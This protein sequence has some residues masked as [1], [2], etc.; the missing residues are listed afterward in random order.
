MAKGVSAAEKKERMLKLFRESKDVFTK[1]EIESRSTK[2]GIISNAVEGVLKELVGDDLV[3]EEKVGI[4]TYWW[5][6]PGEDAAK[7][8][9]ELSEQ[10]AAVAE[11]TPKLEQLQQQK[12]AAAAAAGGEGDASELQALEASID[13]LR[14]RQKAASEEL[15]KLTKHGSCAASTRRATECRS[16]AARAGYAHRSPAPC[17]HPCGAGQ[18]APRKGTAA[19]AP[20]AY[21]PRAC[22]THRV[23]QAPRTVDPRYLVITPGAEDWGARKADLTVLLEGA[24][25]WTD[26]LCTPMCR[27]VAQRPRPMRPPA[28]PASA[29]ASAGRPPASPSLGQP[30]PTSPSLGQPQPTSPSLAQPRPA[31]ANWQT[32]SGWPAISHTGSR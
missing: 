30:R 8:R 13:A 18:L 17:T 4:S 24:N 1:K 3:R 21:R 31:S 11:L 15:T 27:P 28:R 29:R 12:A 25:R 7:K 16:R 20:Y 10:Q 23:P 26:N 5:S 14:G 32:C 22:R 6:F 9:R 2:V 19:C